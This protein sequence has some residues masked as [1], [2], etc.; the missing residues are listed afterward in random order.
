MGVV[1]TGVPINWKCLGMLQKIKKISYYINICYYAYYIDISHNIRQPDKATPGEKCDYLA[2]K[3]R[4]RDRKGGGQPRLCGP[5][6]AATMS[7]VPSGG[8]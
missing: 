1:I 2:Q 5:I 8:G 6:F 3:P 4:W 7:R